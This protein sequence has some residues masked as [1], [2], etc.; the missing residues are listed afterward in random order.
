MIETMDGVKAPKDVCV[1]SVVNIY[2]KNDDERLSTCK[3]KQ[4]ST[5]LPNLKV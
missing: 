1:V 2:C 4:E 5:K 3:D